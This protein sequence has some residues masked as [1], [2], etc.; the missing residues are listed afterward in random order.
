MVWMATC[1]RTSPHNV[2]W[3]S[4]PFS[5][6]EREKGPIQMSTEIISEHF[7]VDNTYWSMNAIGSLE[8]LPHSHVLIFLPT[9]KDFSFI[10]FFCYFGP[11][12][13]SF[14]PCF[15]SN[16]SKVSGILRELCIHNR[17]CTS[18]R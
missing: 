9:C 4:F 13:N 5:F 7:W 6:I 11:S 12:V 10:D 2:N 17:Q 3:F 1:Y 8:N 18:H 14:C 16:T 15:T